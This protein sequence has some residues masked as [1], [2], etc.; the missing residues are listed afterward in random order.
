M[1]FCPIVPSHG[2]AMT[3]AEIGCF[4]LDLKRKKQAA[5]LVL[6]MCKHPDSYVCAWRVCVCV[7]N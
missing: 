6:C 7:R 1:N 5:A 4:L 3:V 2:C